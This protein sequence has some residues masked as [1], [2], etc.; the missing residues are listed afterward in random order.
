ML[1]VKC[2]KTLEAI[3]HC[4]RRNLSQDVALPINCIAFSYSVFEVDYEIMNTDSCLH[5][6]CMCVCMLVLCMHICIH[7]CLCVCMFVL[8]VCMY[9][10]LCIC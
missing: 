8:Y 1:L 4:V 10:F 6:I 5:S 9:V 3:L 7:L 2:S